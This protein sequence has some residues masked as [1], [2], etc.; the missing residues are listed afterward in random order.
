[1]R[2]PGKDE[3]EALKTVAGAEAQ[4]A[5]EQPTGLADLLKQP[6]GA[7][8]SASADGQAWGAL[9]RASEAAMA[10]GYRTR[11]AEHLGRLACRSRFADGAVAAGV[12]RRASG[13][14]FKGDPGAPSW[15]ASR[16]PTARRAQNHPAPPPPRPR[17]RHRGE[18]GGVGAQLRAVVQPEAP[19][20]RSYSRE[21]RVRMAP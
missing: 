2:S 20:R 10:D 5:G 11:L 15:S 1:M 4:P 17:R 7:D 16:P 18:E 9:L 13:P 8:W 19:K 12:A 14:S 21:M 3:V 6:A